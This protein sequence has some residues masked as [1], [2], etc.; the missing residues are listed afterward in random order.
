MINIP[1]FI[2]DI[3][4]KLLEGQLNAVVERCNVGAVCVLTTVVS[5]QSGHKDSATPRSH[6]R[7]LWLGCEFTGIDS[8]HTLPEQQ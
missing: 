6:W 8:I 4:V 2:E 7:L 3:D 5:H 1:R